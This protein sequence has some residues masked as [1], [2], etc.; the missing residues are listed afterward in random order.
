MTTTRSSVK[1]VTV[2]QYNV[3]RSGAR[4]ARQIVVRIGHPDTLTF[5]EKRS[6][7]RFQLPIEAAFKQAV[8]LHA[9][10]AARAKKEAKAAKV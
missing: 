9:I 4:N 7:A 8:R 10:A 1:R 3:I 5:S 6:R 2:F